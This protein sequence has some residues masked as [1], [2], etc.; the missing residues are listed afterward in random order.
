MVDSGEWKLGGLDVLSA[1]AENEA[2]VHV[3]SSLFG[4]WL[5]GS[6]PRYR[7][8]RACC[9]TTIGFSHQRL[10]RADGAFTSKTLGLP[11]MLGALPT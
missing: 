6:L 1:V 9:R 8:I 5:C 2:I 4:L 10:Q 7:R 11:L 3:R